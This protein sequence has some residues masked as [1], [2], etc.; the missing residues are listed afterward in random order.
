MKILIDMSNSP[1]VLFF[2]PIIKRLE[3]KGHNVKII[4]RKHA[5]TL[6][7]LDLFKLKYIVIGKHAGK[8][9]FSKLFN[10]VGRVLAIAKYI[11]QENPDI[12]LSHQSPYIIYAGFLKNKKSVYIFDNEY[13]KL[14]NNLTFPLANKVIYPEAMGLDKKNK[15]FVRYPGIKEAVY[16]ADFK[17]NLKGIEKIKKI[18]GKKILIRTEISNAV[19]HIGDPLFKLVTTLAFK[20][21][22]IILSPRTEEQKEQYKKIK[23]VIVLE[24]PVHAPSLMKYVDLVMSAGGTMNR[25]AAV[26][27]VPVISLYSGELLEVDKWLIKKGLMVYNTNPSIELIEQ[28]I[29]KKN[30]KKEINLKKLGKNAIDKIVREVE[31][32]EK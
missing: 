14:Q 13:A 24:K 30:K 8:N 25:E 5:Q 7:L 9:I 3:K 23:N 18:K 19:Y 27:E 1:H 15:K 20:G 31:I 32:L 28:V 4:A 16:L 29:K 11:R 2:Y 10:A 26:L 6:G 22:K 21:Y 17:S 12:C